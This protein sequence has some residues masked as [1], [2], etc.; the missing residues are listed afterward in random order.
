MH[1]FGKI[2][3]LLFVLVSFETRGQNLADNLL[4]HYNL[5]NTVL[6]GS[7]NDFHGENFGGTGAPDRFNNP[8]ACISL[9]NEAYVSLPA[10]NELEPDFPF[11]FSMW[12]Y[13]D[14]FNDA[15][16]NFS[17]ISTDMALDN[18]SGAF[19]TILKN[20][21]ELLIGFGNLPGC[22]SPGC[23]K[24]VKSIEAIEENQWYHMA[25][26]FAS[27][28]DF[29]IYLNGCEIP[30]EPNGTGSSN[31]SYSGIPGNLG[32][33][34]HS[35]I[36]NVPLSYFDGKIDEFYF[37]DRVL[38]DTDVA[39]LYDNFY[40]TPEIDLSYNGCFGDNYEVIVNDNT[41]NEQNPTGIETIPTNAIVC[42]TIVNINL[43]FEDCQDDMEE[44]EEE[45][46]IQDDEPDTD[47]SDPDD[48]SIVIEADEDTVCL[49]HFVTA[50]SPNG[51]GDNDLYQVFFPADCSFM[52]YELT[53]YNRWGATV[54]EGDAYN[55]WDGTLKS[56]KCEIGVY[57]VLI[58]F[59]HQE[60]FR[61]AK[62]NVTLIR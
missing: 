14:N 9:E 50:F 62:G 20:S 35:S 51:D 30:T 24:G 40:P 32:R 18:Y 53:I 10:N 12:F 11:S 34:D 8:D 41:Y 49:P 54:F 46:E 37:W 38:T 33:N 25:V 60:E 44:E 13:T 29:T 21:H 23:R 52:D 56:N 5:N 19:V 31:I 43:V 39:T 57:V 47:I 27:P 59:V 3:L 15:D 4:I 6:D 16:N 26:I 42:D 58:K 2:L 7:G 28:N 55:H 22:T 36:G 17:L 48:P 45:E 61:F 1:T